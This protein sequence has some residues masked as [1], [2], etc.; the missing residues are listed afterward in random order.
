[1]AVEPVSR[2]Q[3]GTSRQVQKGRIGTW[4]RGSA[5]RWQ[6][7]EKTE[8]E[9]RI[10]EWEQKGQDAWGKFDWELV[11][12]PR[13]GLVSREENAWVSEALRSGGVDE[14]EA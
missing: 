14:A 5:D 6:E 11:Q 8:E 10:Q 1:M 7:D 9:E 12:W 4:A 3:A 2:L 13:R